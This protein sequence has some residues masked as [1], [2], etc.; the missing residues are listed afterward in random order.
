MR[1]LV[2]GAAGFLGLATTRCAVAAG[3]EVVALVRPTAVLDDP[4]WRDDA[5]SVVR[6]DLRQHGP[7]VADLQ[8]VDTVVH[9]AAA[10]SGDLPTQFQ[11]T[12]L[13]TENLLRWVDLG[14]V[15]R[16]VHISSF[17]VYDFAAL[18]AGAVLDET[19]PI[20][21]SPRSRDAYTTTKLLQEAMVRAAAEQ[22][23]CELVVL[24]PGAI[25]GPGKDWNHGA[26]VA[27]GSRASLVF[28][29]SATF[30][31]AYVDNCA[32]AI[33]AACVA[34]VAGRTLNIVDDELPTHLEF[35]RACAHAGASTGL[36]VPVPWWLVASVGRAVDLVNSRL[37]GGRAKLPEFLAY[38]RQQARWKPLRYSNQLAKSAL[39]WHPQVSLAEGVRR[40]VAGDRHAE[41]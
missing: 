2:T 39:R 26:A 14:T 16:I 35:H 40:T 1:L 12:V 11:G 36:A 9:L 19:S 30:R 5:V 15:R 10:A 21:R 20:E 23:G 18:D 33:V 8:G 29:P 24:R 32:D 4:V 3:H 38:I 31:L 34:P 22:A 28:A 37:L 6:G 27:L 13:A 41:R 7:W 17:S 25:Y